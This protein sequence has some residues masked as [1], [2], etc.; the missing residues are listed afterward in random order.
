MS[1]PPE[2]DPVRSRT[3][4]IRTQADR[5]PEPSAAIIDSQS[6]KTTEESGLSVPKTRSIH[7]RQALYTS[8]QA[9]RRS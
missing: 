4:R 8:T 3:R 2:L 5:Q 6:V 9:A 7:K 1:R